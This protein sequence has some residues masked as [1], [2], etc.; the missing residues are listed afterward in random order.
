MAETTPYV[1]FLG[2]NGALDFL[3]GLMSDAELSEVSDRGLGLGLEA[4]AGLGGRVS[5]VDEVALLLGSGA[6]GAGSS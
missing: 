4:S 5:T 1:K 2:S 3:I 6:G